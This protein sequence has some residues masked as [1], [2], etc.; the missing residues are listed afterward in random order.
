MDN[1]EA[2]ATLGTHDTGQIN[3]RETRKE[4]SNQI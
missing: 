2:L 3:N 4:R 1:L